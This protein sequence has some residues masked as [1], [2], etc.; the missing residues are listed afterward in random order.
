[1]TGITL[2]NITSYPDLYR[3]FADGAN[4]YLVEYN[5]FLAL[6]MPR[7][8]DLMCRLIWDLRQCVE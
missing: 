8:F 4:G 5:K 6:G 2:V 3:V 7:F 1:M